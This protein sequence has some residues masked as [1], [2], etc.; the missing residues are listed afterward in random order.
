MERDNLQ[1]LEC[2]D[3]EE[4]FPTAKEQDLK[5]FFAVKD[6]FPTATEKTAKRLSK[7]LFYLNS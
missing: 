1:G 3:T 2:Q 4:G 7:K 6:D 5:A